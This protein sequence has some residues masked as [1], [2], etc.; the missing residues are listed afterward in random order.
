MVRLSRY[1]PD[2]DFELFGKLESLNPGGSIKDRPAKEILEAGL[3]AGEIGPGTVVVESSSGNM[4]IGLAQACR[5]HGLR[6]VCVVDPKTTTQNLRVLEA[7]GAKIDF[8]DE[9]DPATG[10]FLQ[11]RIE[12]VNELLKT[13]EGAFWPNQ[14]A[15]RNNP[16]SHY[17][18]TMHEVVTALDGRVD[19]VFAAVST[20]GTVHGC[21]EYIRD[22]RLGA[23]I[24]AVDARGSVIFGD[25]KAERRIPGLGAGINPP[26][27]DLALIHNFVHV[28]DRDCVA[29]CRRLVQR[30]A[31]LVGGSAGGVIAAVEKWRDRIPA[32]ARCVAILCD[33]GERYLD[34]VYDD[35]WVH[36]HL[37][38]ID[39]DWAEPAA[40]MGPSLEHSLSASL[41]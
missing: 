40:A 8:V 24:I 41:S 39:E 32:G 7:Y 13:I 6:F 12:R 3:R 9:P 11:A 23:R 2:A 35:D 28:T 5:Y 15:N 20:C 21:A 4:G 38:D 25:A 22:H 29:G 33:R 27:C 26:L 18:T 19:F 31:I 17:R 16:V 37:G 30:E 1:L 34:T 14:Y 10:E 36:R